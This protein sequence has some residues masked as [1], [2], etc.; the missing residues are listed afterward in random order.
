MDLALDS[1]PFSPR[2]TAAVA[3]RMHGE[4]DAR[5]AWAQV[6][7]ALRDGESIDGLDD[8]G[9]PALCLASQFQSREGVS[10]LLARGADANASTFA[11]GETPLVFF[12]FCLPGIP[13]AE[14]L[15]CLRLLCQAGADPNESGHGRATP[16]EDMIFG[17]CRLYGRELAAFGARFDHKNADGETLVHRW[18]SQQSSFVA[19]EEE[20]DWVLAQAQSVGAPLDVNA[21][22]SKGLSAAGK[23]ASA[24]K[25]RAMQALFARGANPF[26]VSAATSLAELWAPW[27]PPRNHSEADQRFQTLLD[28][29]EIQWALDAGQPAP[30]PSRR[31]PRI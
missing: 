12:A 25:F 18:V 15:G 1:L 24:G 19:H 21:F 16:F 14:A 17:P 5:V 4:L 29:T 31:A 2:V 11:G 10:E 3:A 7:A 23:A 26:S 27:R 30:G 6:D 28:A 22:D 13:E 9:V 8:R 20:L